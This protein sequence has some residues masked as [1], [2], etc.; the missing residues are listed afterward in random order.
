MA[1]GDR[2]GRFSVRFEVLGPLRVSREDGLPVRLVS[3]RQRALLTALILHANRTVP[4]QRLIAALW[5]DDAPPSARGLVSTYVWRVRGLLADRPGAD[6]AGRATTTGPAGGDRTAGGGAPR[7]V[8][9]PRGYRLPGRPAGLG[10]AAGR[11][12][13]TAGRRRTG[14]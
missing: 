8:G 10:V 3:G 12:P 1:G 14:A 6:P 2:C 9:E 7:I 13:A 4:V 11:R 5:G